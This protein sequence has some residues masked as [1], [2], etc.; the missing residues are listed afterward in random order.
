MTTY[1]ARRLLTVGPVLVIISI[2]IF[3]LVRLAP[4]DPISIMFD[5]DL[6]AVDPEYIAR[7]QAELGLDQPILI[8][9]LAWLGE[10]VQGNVGYSIVTGR[11]AL[12]MVMERLPATLILMG[13]ALLIAVVLGVSLGIVA[14]LRRNTWVDYL[15]AAVSL[16]GISVPNF[17]LALGGIYIFAL[18]LGLLPSAGMGPPDQ[19]IDLRYLIM[20]A[21]I[22]GFTLAGQVVRYVRSGL[23]EELGKDYVLVAEAKGVP[24]RSIVVWH[25]LRNSLIP[26]ITILALAVPS[27]LSGAV[28]L[29]QIFAWPGMGRLAISSIA[30]RDYPVIIAFTLLISIFVLVFN[31]LAD[32][33]Y[34]M[35]DSRVRLG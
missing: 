12:S 7:R 16:A 25:A 26:L 11:S 10:V 34:A 20:P 18:T 17:F 19:F 22:L 1:I 5:P 15:T 21:G 31:M 27:M 29:E 14:A 9:Y 35:V 8:Q 30:A 23:L 32:V 2:L 3:V 33:L 4:G 13:A 6:S 28:I 24:Y